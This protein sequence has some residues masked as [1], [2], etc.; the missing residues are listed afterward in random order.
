M[1]VGLLTAQVNQQ[2]LVHMLNFGCLSV[3]FLPASFSQ[4]EE[5]LCAAAEAIS[6]MAVL[7]SSKQVVGNE[8]GIRSLVNLLQHNSGRV[9]GSAVAALATVLVE[10]QANCM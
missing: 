10:A 2:F 8:G 4:D 9:R 5:V 1:F 6:S 7:T 3:F